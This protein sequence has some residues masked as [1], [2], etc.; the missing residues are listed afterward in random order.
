[1]ATEGSANNRKLILACFPRK[2]SDDGLLPAIERYDGPAFRI[3]RRFLREG[4]SEAPDI[5]T[6]SAEY[7]LICRDLPIAMYDRK[8]TPA[9]ARELRPLV[10]AELNRMTASLSS[11]E[12]LVFVGKQYLPVPTCLEY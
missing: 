4:P 5:H 2:R 11:P 1:M 8:M 7:G 12:T 3:L 6:L 10:L 9:R